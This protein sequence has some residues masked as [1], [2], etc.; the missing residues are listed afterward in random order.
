MPLAHVCLPCSTGYVSLMLPM[1]RGSRVCLTLVIQGHQRDIF[2]P[3]EA[4]PLTRSGW[5][6]LGF[7]FKFLSPSR[8]PECGSPGS[9]QMAELRTP[10]S[11][12]NFP[13]SLTSVSFSSCNSLLRGSASMLPENAPHRSPENHSVNVNA[14]KDAI[15]VG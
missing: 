1:T 8:Q 11:N 7:C 2:L 14:W 4:H 10:C 9:D 13:S 5:R 15:S 12:Q 3:V 6:T